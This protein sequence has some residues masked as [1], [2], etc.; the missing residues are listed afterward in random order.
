VR[1]DPVTLNIV[2]K[3]LIA[4]AR[5]MAVNMRRASYSTVVREARDFSVGV[6]DTDGSVVAQAE[7]IPV[8]TGGITQAF[9]CL[10]AEVD[11]RA[12]TPDD[13][14][15]VNDPFRGGQHL[16]DIF[17]FTPIFVDGE[18][19]AYGASV[20]HHVDVGGGM[21]GLN[22]DAWEIYQEGLRLPLARFSVSRDWN[23][24]F[25]ERIVAANVRVPTQVLGDLNAQFTANLTAEQRLGDLVARYGRDCVGAVMAELKD[26]AERRTREGIAQIPDGR[27]EGE[28]F[29][30]GTPWGVDRIRIAVTVEV[31]GTDMRFDFT[32]TD[33]QVRANVNSPLA[34]TISAVQA[35]V[36]GVL[37]EKDIPFNEGCNRPLRVEVPYGSI[38]NPR[39]P[40][41]VRARMTPASRAFNAIIRA[42]SVA[43]PERV[44]ASGFDTTT[45][46]SLSHLDR[47]SGEY[48]VVIEILGGGWGAGAS[49]DGADALDNPLSNCANAPVEALEIACDYFRV[50]EFQ[51]LPDSG[52]AGRHRGG[53][54]FQRT[55]E[56]LRDGVEFAAYSDHHRWGARGLF[57]GG[58]GSTG[59]FV[60]RPRD[61]DERALPCVTAAR[62]NAGDTISIRV[63]GGGGYGVPDPAGPDVP[64]GHP[65]GDRIGRRQP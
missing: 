47:G 48:G 36:R 4:T 45:S 31:A 60:L 10:A 55:Y 25:V 34:S 62:L 61:R 57:G 50:R 17:L 24:G 15:L 51:L 9:R 56:S 33:E 46:V 21:P 39:P 23:G 8:Q 19:L 65:T 59:A 22:A 64:E 12:V 18:L 6:L 63:G 43:V 38:L 37:H 1:A 40:A 32:G 29:L 41:A 28:A 13:G 53:L 7:M 44:T 27:Y 42:L 11:M 14:F 5:E 54:G 26:Y 58:S 35:A 52:G 20:A 3:A 2:G 49:H 30:E 16:Q